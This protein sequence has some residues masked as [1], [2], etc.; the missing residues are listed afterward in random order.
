MECWGF[1][2]RDRHWLWRC[3]DDARQGVHEK[4]AAAQQVGSGR[5]CREQDGSCHKLL[6]RGSKPTSPAYSPSRLIGRLRKGTASEKS[7]CILSELTAAAHTQRHPGTHMSATHRSRSSE[8]HASTVISR[9]QFQS[10]LLCAAWPP[11]T[12]PPVCASCL[13]PRCKL[14]PARRKSEDTTAPAVQSPEKK[15]VSTGAG[16]GAHEAAHGGE[17]AGRSHGGGEKDSPE[18]RLIACGESRWRKLVIH[19][20]ARV[21]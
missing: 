17:R 6:T 11:A 2:P 20:L 21:G 19:R 18:H 5:R 4:D 14:S 1:A 13:P 3:R 9:L 15:A 8:T 10:D 12:P 7:P 16:L